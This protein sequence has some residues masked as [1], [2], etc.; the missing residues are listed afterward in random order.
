MEKLT[1]R[2]LAE[3]ISNLSEEAKDKQAFIL[4]GDESQGRPIKELCVVEEDIY[5]DKGDYEDCGTIE[6]LEEAKGDEFNIEDYEIST[7]KGTA[8]LYCDE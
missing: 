3:T 7:P 5:A 6:D 8:Y 2:R 1:W 4:I